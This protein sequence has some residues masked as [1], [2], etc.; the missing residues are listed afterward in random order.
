GSSARPGGDVTEASRIAAAV[1]GVQGLVAAE[2]RA[3]DLIGDGNQCGPLRCTG[4]CP[5]HN[6]RTAARSVDD[7]ESGVGIGVVGHV[8]IQSQP[9]CGDFKAVAPRADVFLV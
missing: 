1:N 6:K 3:P 7:I 8:R 2:S 9:K 5:A 4:A